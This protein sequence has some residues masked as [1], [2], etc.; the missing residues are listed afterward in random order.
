MENYALVSPS[1]KKEFVKLIF[2][3]LFTTQSK[4]NKG[5]LEHARKG[6]IRKLP[7]RNY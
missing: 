6:V 3:N 1:Y 5:S 4:P 2:G 7:I